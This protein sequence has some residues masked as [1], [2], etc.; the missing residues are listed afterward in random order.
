M[1]NS[2][3]HRAKMSPSP[4]NALGYASPLKGEESEVDAL[5][6]GAYDARLYRYR[7]KTIAQ[8]P[9][10]DRGTE[11]AWGYDSTSTNPKVIDMGQPDIG[12]H[13]YRR[14]ADDDPP[15]NNPN[16]KIEVSFRQPDLSKISDLDNLRYRMTIPPSVIGGNPTIIKDFE[17]IDYQ[18]DS[19]IT[20]SI[21]EGLEEKL[22][23]ETRYDLESYSQIGTA[24][25]P[26]E[27]TQKVGFTVIVDSI[28]PSV[29]V[30]Q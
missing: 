19:A 16:R 15:T 12:Y 26:S 13:Y 7:S 3:S 8:S 4:R 20:G 14:V 18:N 9:A 27:G 5:A 29:S 17:W 25:K 24:G 23:E 2:Q 10:I 22:Q 30:A 6:C 28:K 1:V 11:D 21:V